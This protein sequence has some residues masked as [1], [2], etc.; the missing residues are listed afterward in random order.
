MKID[1]GIM[2]NNPLEAGPAFGNIVMTFF[3]GDMDDGMTVLF[4]DEA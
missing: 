2:I 1:A 4:F 3:E